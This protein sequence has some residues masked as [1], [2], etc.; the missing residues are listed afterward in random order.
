MAWNWQW[1]PLT[2]P[3]AG[4]TPS[5]AGRRLVEDCVGHVSGTESRR[6]SDR[7][8]GR[9]AR[10]GRGPVGRRPGSEVDRRAR[11]AAR[12]WMAKGSRSE[13][14]RRRSR[15]RL[16]RVSA[17]TS[18]TR[19]TRPSRFLRAIRRC[20]AWRSVAALGFDAD[21]QAPELRHRVPGP[22]YPAAAGAPRS[23]RVLPREGVPGSDQA[24][25]GGPDP[26]AAIRRGRHAGHTERLQP[27]DRQEHPEQP[28]ADV[29]C[30]ASFDLADPR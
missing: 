24:G 29:S 21:P 16:C 6:C 5:A 15:N 8:G 12:P 18:T 28:E 19:S 2:D 22:R 3:S 20:R 30:R 14:P 17:S 10:L 13:S 27:H 1:N 7:P 25:D 11:R 9:E 23:S 4:E 26:G